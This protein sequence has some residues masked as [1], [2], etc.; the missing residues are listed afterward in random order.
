M[1]GNASVQRSEE[2]SKTT[3]EEQQRGG[4][5]RQALKAKGRKYFKG[6]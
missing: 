3:K 2:S 4:G 1:P 5:I 6:K